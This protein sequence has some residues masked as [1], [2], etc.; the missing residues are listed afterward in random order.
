MRMMM[1]VIENTV[2]YDDVQVIG[3]MVVMMSSHLIVNFLFFFIILSLF[4]SCHLSLFGHQVSRI[5][6]LRMFL[7][8][9]LGMLRCHH[10]EWQLAR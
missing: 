4:F 5:M 2:G 7:N 8:G 3:L 9:C 1:V 6:T 10:Q